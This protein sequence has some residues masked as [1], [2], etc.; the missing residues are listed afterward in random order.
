VVNFE[1]SR[2]FSEAHRVHSRLNVFHSI[3]AGPL[4]IALPF[5]YRRWSKRVA[6]SFSSRGVGL[7]DETV[8]PWDK[9]IQ[10]DDTIG[11]TV[12]SGSLRPSYSVKPVRRTDIKIDDGRVVNVSEVWLSNY[13]DVHD[14]LLELPAASGIYCS[15]MDV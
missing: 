15:K 11:F 9:V 1:R 12:E 8:V 7:S 2:F 4:G 13:K 6:R 5:L 14:Y 10:I 3:S